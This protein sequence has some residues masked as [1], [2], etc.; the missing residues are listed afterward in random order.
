MT[1]K[2]CIRIL[3]AMIICVATCF[4]CVLAAC[5][6]AKPVGISIIN[7]EDVTVNVGDIFTLKT[8]VEMSDGSKYAGKVNWSTDKE[9]IITSE[10]NAGGVYAAEKAGEVTVTASIPDTGYSASCK[11]E[12]VEPGTVF[13]VGV[14][15]DVENFGYRNPVTGEYTGF[16]IELAQRLGGELGYD[17]MKYVTVTPDNREEKLQNGEVDCVIATYSVTPERENVVNFSA[18]YYRDYVQVLKGANY[19]TDYVSADVND[20]G[21][22][23]I[24]KIAGYVFPGEATETEITPCRVGTVTGST[25]YQA[26]LDYCDDNG[27][28]VG[29]PVVGDL[30]ENVDTFGSYKECE[31]ALESGEI[32]LFVADS[33]ILVSH[34]PEGATLLNDRLESQDYAVGTRKGDESA[35]EEE[36]TQ[37]TEDINRLIDKWLE[38]EDGTISE[39]LKKYGLFY[40]DAKPGDES[41]TV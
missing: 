17:K 19:G 27:I 20:E 24:S 9:G 39:L 13:R 32:D 10:S 34:T 38:E 12:V 36:V 1:K 41:D 8:D 2:R 30:F 6:S 4:V 23:S 29:D 14:K 3:T 37:L 7:G 11:V 26:F 21:L 18:P 33:S 22:D 25:A 35:G 16:E 31:K 28:E 40:D 15:Y 5:S